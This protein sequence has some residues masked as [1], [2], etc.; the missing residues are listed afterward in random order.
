M[1]AVLVDSGGVLLA[2]SIIWISW[3]SLHLSSMGN[4]S[5]LLKQVGRM[6]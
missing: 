2:D 6:I 1:Q 4:G 3:D 5:T